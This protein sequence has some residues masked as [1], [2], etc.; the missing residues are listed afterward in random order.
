MGEQNKFRSEQS[1][2]NF[3]KAERQ[4]ANAQ[5]RKAF[6]AKKTELTGK[7]ASW[8][9]ANK[10]KAALIAAAAVLV[11]VLVWLGCKWFVGPD[12]SV[13]YFFGTLVGKQG[14]WLVI[15]TAPDGEEP[16]Y[17]HLADFDIP[18]GYTRDDYSVFKDGIQQDFFCI[19][20][21][22]SHVVQ[23]VYISAAKNLS[24]AE[25]PHTLLSYGLHYPSVQNV[26][27]SS[28]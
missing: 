20:N 21:D 5:K 18:A 12:G 4:R 8:L 25:Y 7:V 16:R 22:E 28:P 24:A 13:P 11:L 1:R 9:S 2:K 27:A 6:T 23:D 26:L 3:E 19:A 17:Y 10:K 15:N 14:N